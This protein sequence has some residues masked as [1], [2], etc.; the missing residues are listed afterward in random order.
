MGNAVEQAREMMGLWGKRAE[1]VEQL[2]AVDDQIAQGSKGT[3]P[4]PAPAK[5]K[6]TVAQKTNGQRRKKRKPGRPK[7][8]RNKPKETAAETQPE[9]QAPAPEQTQEEMTASGKRFRNRVSLK[10]LICSIAGTHNDGIKL[11]DLVQACYEAGY[12]STSD[13]KGFVQNI[14]TNLNSL[15]NDGKVTKDDDKRYHVAAA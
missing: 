10:E 11:D 9:A 15:M 4:A 2:N 8:S 7:G 13:R 3:T 1:L 12:R 14:R 6:A 5:P